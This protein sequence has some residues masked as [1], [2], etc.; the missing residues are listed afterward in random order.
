MINLLLSCYIVSLC[1]LATWYALN[2]DD[3]PFSRVGWYL[4]KLPLV[5]RMPL[6]ECLICM[7][8]I[9]GSVYLII[10]QSLFGIPLNWNFLLSLLVIAGL[11]V[12]YLGLMKLII[13]VNELEGISK[14]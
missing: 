4:R 6:F 5:L 2:D 14:R 9:W 3:S 10:V 11:E 12:I 7:S 13:K 8:S 1:V